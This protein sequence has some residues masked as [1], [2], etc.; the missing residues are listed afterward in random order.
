MEK[1][2]FLVAHRKI[3]LSI[4]LGFLSLLLSSY[5][6]QVIIRDIQVNIPWTIFMPILVALAY[7]WKYGLAAGLSGGA[8]FP[9]LLWSN[10]G[11]G[12]FGTS[13]I[14][15]AFFTFLG[16]AAE[17]I[18]FKKIT[19]SL[20]RILIAVIVSILCLFVFDGFLFI[21]F[22]GMNPPFWEPNTLSSLPQELMWQ[23]AFKD[24]ANI[25]MLTVVSETLLRISYVRSFL[26]LPTNQ[27]MHSNHKILF[28]SLSTF[29][30]VWLL[31][32]GLGNSLLEGSDALQPVHL[33]ISFIVFINSGFI[34]SRVLFFYNELHFETRN[35]L[36]QSEKKYRTIF[37][38]VQDVFYRTNAE[39]IV[40]EISPSVKYFSDF[41]KCEIIGNPVSMLYYNP[42]DRENLINAITLNGELRDYELRL[43]TKSGDLRYASINARLVLGHDGSLS[44]IDEAIRDITERKK[45]ELDLVRTKEKAEESDRLKSAFLA[46]MSHEIRTPMNGILGFASLLKEPDLTGEEQ[47]NYI[48]IIEKSGNRMLNIINDIVDISKIESGTMVTKIE[49][50]NIN[51]QIDFIFNFYKPDAE[52]K[53]ILMKISLLFPNK[54]ATIL[55]DREKL[56]AILTNLVRNAIKFT[57]KG[58]IELGYDLVPAEEAQSRQMVLFY[59]EDTGAGIPGNR[60]E[61]IFERFIQADIDD[62]MAL[63]GAGLG[64]AIAKSYVEMLGGKIWVKS[65][66]GYGS[67]FFFTL[68]YVKKEDNAEVIDNIQ[69]SQSTDRV[70]NLKILLAEDD[71]VSQKLLSLILQKYCR[72]ILIV[73][74]GTQAIEACQNHPDIDLILMDIQMPEMGGLECTKKIRQFNTEVAIIAQTAFG[75]SSDREKAISAGCNDYISK[76]VNG[77]ILMDMINKYGKPIQQK[78]HYT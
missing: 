18:I 48:N 54:E 17:R 9:F 64:L 8:L 43:K 76:P 49:E 25:V 41:D 29:I 42:E 55:T 60:Q 12:N 77:V 11:W 1:Q 6:I 58:S 39:G 65:V 22:L 26:G 71:Q 45:L 31:S 38:N 59:V 19:N 10:N 7:G 34:V 53:G 24:S 51:E 30:L 78:R 73:S 36:N 33:K 37:E 52:A 35:N 57:N 47:Q 61:A 32:V 3:L 70:N 15:L 4:L 50:S 46:N 16:F 72:E 56:F 68:P 66:E 5:G 62:P 2:V 14:F 74:S 13:L 69:S 75:F 27:A 63:Q 44:H 67:T 40:L 23:F 28:V 20:I 21:P